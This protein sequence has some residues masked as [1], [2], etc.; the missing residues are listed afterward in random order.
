MSVIKKSST[1]KAEVREKAE[2]RDNKVDELKERVEH[3]EEGQRKTKERVSELDCGLSLLVEESESL[4]V[5]Y[6]TIG[7]ERKEKWLMAGK[8]PAALMADIKKK[9]ENKVEAAEGGGQAGGAEVAEG[10]GPA[11]M[12]VDDTAKVMKEILKELSEALTIEN[13]KRLEA[14]KFDQ[15]VDGSWVRRKGW[16]LIQL[17]HNDLSL[18]ASRLIKQ[19]VDS[20]IGKCNVGGDR[21]FQLYVQKSEGERRRIRDKYDRKKG[22]G[23]GKDGGKGGGGKGKDWGKGGKGKNKGN[24]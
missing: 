12:E 2:V 22:K 3:L 4:E 18:K 21:G 7:E 17:E 16:F 6:K 1:K 24:K 13:V 20:A 14:N 10:G 11:A 5:I 8:V 23:K 9:L 15:G 19:H